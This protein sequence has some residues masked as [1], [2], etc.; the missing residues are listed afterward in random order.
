M[1]S[2]SQNHHASRPEKSQLRQLRDRG[3]AADG[4]ERAE[5]ACSGTAS[6]SRPRD[7]RE[8]VVRHARA[9]LL[10]GRRHAGHGL[11]VLVDAREIAR[12][13]NFRMRGQAQIGLHAHASGAVEFGAE[14]FAER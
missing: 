14:L 10:G 12:D 2:A 11:A 9:H 3:M 7:A 13:E 6:V 5:V 1:C 4:R 8:D